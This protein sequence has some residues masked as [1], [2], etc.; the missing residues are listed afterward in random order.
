MLTLEI[1]YLAYICKSS[2]TIN[3]HLVNL[4]NQYSDNCHNNKHDILEYSDD[5]LNYFLVHLIDIAEYWTDIET[6]KEADSMV[7]NYYRL[8]DL[9]RYMHNVLNNLDAYR[10]K[11]RKAKLNLPLLCNFQLADSRLTA[12]HIDNIKHICNMSL[13]N[14]VLY[15][16]SRKEKSIP[17]NCGS[18]DITFN[19]TKKVEMKGEINTE[20][21]SLNNVYDYYLTET[22]EKLLSICF[23]FM[24]GYR[25]FLIQITCA[26]I[27]IKVIDY[28]L[29]DEQMIKMYHTIS[30]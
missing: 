14:V 13:D 11:L 25:C 8:N 6:A 26:D 19:N 7:L 28:I 9:I 12:L 16:D 17:V 10:A 29:P 23:L 1:E 27:D 15:G 22:T 21:Y 2:L 24:I 4:F 18:V 3:N 20:I 5:E 30:S